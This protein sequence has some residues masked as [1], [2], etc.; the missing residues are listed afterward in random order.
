[1]KVSFFLMVA[2]IV[3]FFNGCNSSNKE[4]YKD[5]NLKSE[6][7]IKN[8]KIDGIYKEFYESGELK[9]VANYNNG[10]LN[11][12]SRVFYKN[13]SI[14]S[15]E[16]F[17]RGL[18][19]G[20]CKYYNNFGRIDTIKNF[21]L[22]NPK[23]YKGVDLVN[24][25]KL[26]REVFSDSIRGKV[27]QLNSLMII[28]SGGKVD[29]KKSHYFDILLKNDTISFNDSL[30]A[31]LVFEYRLNAEKTKYAVI[32]FANEKLDLYNVFQTKSDFVYMR[33]KPH[34]RGVNYLCG[35]IEEYTP[36]GFDTLTNVLFFKRKYFVK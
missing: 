31:V 35:Y 32:Q 26:I 2:I 34:K 16:Y 7:F 4:Y 6:Y 11:G 9:L 1:M 25:H 33:Q 8:D 5:G 29:L 23:F 15:I 20:E 13:G 12:A 14:K 10:H 19:N 22:I 36:Y 18:L 17:T 28:N 24:F 21:I 30:N 3:I 27:S